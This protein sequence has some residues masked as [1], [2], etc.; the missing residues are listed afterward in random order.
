MI[1]GED[2]LMIL[3]Q[4]FFLIFITALIRVC[5]VIRSDM[6]IYRKGSASVQASWFLPQGSVSQY[7][8]PI[9]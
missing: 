9:H 2:Y 1:S 7:M 3:M 8:S 4:Y 6:V 5:W